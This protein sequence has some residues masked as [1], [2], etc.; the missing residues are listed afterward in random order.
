MGKE[1]E[2]ALRLQGS[3]TPRQLVAEGFRK[4]TVYKVAESL[5]TQQSEAPSA[6][7]VVDLKTDQERY[8]PGSVALATFTVSNRS[9]SD[10]YV[11]QV[12]ARPEWI[13]STDW[14]PATVRRLLSA[15]QS[16]VVRLTIPVPDEV[17]LGEKDVFFGL[18]GQWAG[19]QSLSPSDVMWTGAMIVM[20]QRPRLGVTVF[21]SHS[22]HDRS[23]VNQLE[24][25]LEDNGIDVI[26]PETDPAA[27]LRA[28]RGADFVIAV[29]TQGGRIESVVEELAHAYRHRK[30][31]VLLRS[32]ALTLAMPGV[33]ELPW[34]TVDF[35][36]GAAVVMG[37]VAKYV[38]Q[39]ITDRTLV[40]KKERDD[41]L[42]I[43]VVALGAL[44]AGV[45]LTRRGGPA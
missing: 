13:P 28:I 45:A 33:G 12:G 31:M 3:A 5:R 39:I 2:I 34:A 44:A 41:A 26:L 7:I 11:F 6:P 21:L 38:T 19:P 20:V 14:I 10:L 30:E 36:L 40:R 42:G 15:G 9:Q 18:Q 23:L 8:L 16:M 24:R 22:M 4:S 32:A 25:T 1:D 27:D 29:V 17:T 35:S 43:I 37:E